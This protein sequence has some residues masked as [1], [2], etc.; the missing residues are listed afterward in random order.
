MRFKCRLT[1]AVAFG[2]LLAAPSFVG[3]VAHAQDTSRAAPAEPAYASVAR[4]ASRPRG[5]APRTID[6]DLQ[7][8]PLE[9]AL[10]EI[11]RLGQ[12]RLTYSSDMLPAGR[13]VTLRARSITPVDALRRAL[14]G[15]SLEVIASANGDATI[16]RPALP[17]LTQGV[18]TGRVT[19]AATGSPVDGALVDIVDTQLSDKTGADGRFTLHG[20]PEGTHTV[21]VRRLGYAPQRQ[22]VT[23]A[24]GA[25]VTVQFVL[26]RTAA[27]LE[28][29]VVIGYGTQERRDLTGSIS[30]VQGE[31]ISSVPTATVSQAL[32]GHAAGLDVVSSGVPGSDATFRIRGITTIGNSN[33]L[34]V[35][36]GVP[37][38]SGLNELNPADIASVEV[39]KDASAT[40]IYGAR[41]AN[42]VVIVT[43]KRGSDNQWKFQAY[44]GYQRVAHVVPMLDAAQFASLHNDMMQNAGRPT[45][46]AFAN[47]AQLGRGTDWLGALMAQAPIHSDMA[48]YSA[49]SDRSNVYVSGSML[50]Q[51]GV[52]L[53]T[54]FER[55]TMQIN[56]D[57][58]VRDW[59]SFGNNLTLNHDVNHSGAYNIQSAMAAEPTQ[60]I[61]N[62]DGTFAGPVGRSEWVGDIVNPVGQALLIQNSTD[63]YNLIGSVH[64]DVL[65]S[66][67]LSFRSNLGLQA[68]LWNSRTWSP[69]YN[70]QPTPQD[71]SYLFEQYNRSTTWLADNTLTYARRFAGAH[72]VKLMVGTSAQA[73]NFAFMDGSVQEFQ[74]DRTQ[75]LANGIMSP[76]IGGDESKWGLLSYLGRAN[77]SYKD[78]YLLTAALRRDGS[79]RFG[80]GRKWGLFPS[81]AGAWRISN[82]KFFARVHH[83]DDLKLRVGYGETGNQEIGNYAFASALSTAQY[84]FGNTVVSAVVPSVMP[85][86]NV[87]WETVKQVNVGLDASAFDRRVRVTLDGYVKN[88][89]G[90]LVPMSVPVTT[91]YSDIVTP[92]INAGKIQNRGFEATLSTDELR[93]RVNWST[94]FIFSLNRNTVL[95]LN[96]TVPM[97]VGSIDFN[98]TVARLQ[99]GHPMNSFYGYVTNG[100]FQT[101]QEVDNYAVQV[102]GADPYNRTSPGDIRFKDLN[103]D[104]V[105]NDADRTFLGDPNPAFT[106]GLANS[107]SFGRLDMHLM[108]HG[109]YGNKIFNA[110]RVWTEGM[111]SARNQTTAVENRWTAAGTSNS[112]PRAVFGDPNGN[113]RVSDRYIEDGSYA[114]VKELTI[115]YAIP[116]RFTSRVNA[117][118]AR[119]YVA[120]QNLFTLTHYSGFDPEVGIN[121]ID[122]N[123][124]PVTR[125]MSVGM[126]LGF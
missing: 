111:S 19:D 121:G 91:G 93:G 55:Y 59:L 23:V 49:A 88:T 113:S 21:E 39:L 56:S 82:E 8:A 30:S 106:L 95:S 57:T 12:L 84:N 110:N 52:V 92:F 54:G 27:M 87:H 34:I 47:P 64:G 58:R 98:Y 80:A 51:D 13:T 114:R 11:A 37:T 74:S 50:R 107:V 61:R 36:D 126:N 85:N 81:V 118:N 10:S 48:A 78:T 20:V 45:N 26:Q 73:N 70:W 4:A 109:V 1:L 63:G 79:S 24:S 43:T 35:I 68:N 9:S 77:Y 112:M 31:Q 103:N 104:G 40:A 46:P 122:N 6:V 16:F 72:D 5:V 71:H 62:A 90:M 53:N 119:L 29:V 22:T 101:Q 2:V 32:E 97:P 41:G 33:P 124:Y 108:L 123:V 17:E 44:G 125:T 66:D 115:G 28:N 89:T 65:L 96:D 7:Q 99:Q 38:M 15:T 75:E 83:I 69:K 94:D 18:V 42:G 3:G 120:G 105:I 86:P 76:T 25:T 67:N 116:R 117:A 14:D 102:A 100:V 60:A